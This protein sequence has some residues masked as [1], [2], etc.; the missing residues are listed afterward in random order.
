M[1]KIGKILAIFIGILVLVV[2]VIAIALPFLV[3]PNN[4]KNQI[5][6]AVKQQTGRELKIGGKI[7]WSVFPWIGVEMRQLELSNAP[8]FGNQP[9]AR[10]ETAG[11]KVK[12]LPLLKKVVVVDKVLLA[13]LNLNL[14][15]DR[16]GKTNWDDLTAKKPASTPAPSEG[17]GKP[18][19]NA[20]SIGGIDLRAGEISWKDQ[21]TGAAY[22]L[23]NVELK[24]GALDPAKPVDIKLALDLDSTAPALRTHIDLKTRVTADLDKQTLAVS[25]LAL[26]AAGLR[27]KANA[28]GSQVL[29][30]PQFSGNLEVASFNPRAFL[31][32]IGVKVETA[33]KKALSQAALTTKFDAT[34]KQ[35]RLRDVSAVLD[36]SKL[37]GSLEIINFAQPS[38]RFNL[39]LDNF[40]LDRYLSPAGQTKKSPDPGANKPQQAVIPIPLDA[41]RQLNAQGQFRIGKFKAFGIRASDVLI[42]LAAKDGAIRLNPTQ[43]RLYNGG[44]K[45]ALSLDA[46]QPAPVLNFDEQLTGVELAPLLKDADITNKF[47]GIGN[48]NIKLNGRGGDANNIKATLNGTT[49]FSIKDGTFTGID[50]KKTAD[51]IKQARKEGVSGLKNI[52]PQKAD[53]TKFSQLSASAQIKNGVA[54]SDDLVVQV[55]GL[56]KVTGKGNANLA[57]DLLDYVIYVEDIPIK[58]T[59]ALTDPKF[60]LDVDSILKGEAQKKLKQEG[61]KLEDQL[62]DRLKNLRIK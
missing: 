2:I 61:K 20:I 13:G 34:S 48:I 21:A 24:S 16:M 28:T 51:Q 19:I 22:A 47:S 58:I 59:G 33:D 10:I 62:R 18:A 40:D 4:Y 29:S 8:G 31:E 57:K 6:Q 54:Q 35:A 49:E 15:K 38:Y 3:D 27:L 32:K 14:A 52:I 50:L 37:N 11:V 55:P 43:A 9:F 25:D 39:I 41:I 46:R 44:Y 42:S 36:D 45:G 1:K 7:G 60:T 26:E 53:Q 5:I 12:L 17:G 56:V 23:H 30:A